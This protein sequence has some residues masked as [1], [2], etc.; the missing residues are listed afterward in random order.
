LIA[1]SCFSFNE[2]IVAFDSG[3]GAV[4][5]ARTYSSD[6]FFNYNKRIK[7]I[8]TS[9]GASP[10]TYVLSD[11]KA[12]FTSCTG[13]HF[14]KFDPKTVTAHPSSWTKKTTGSTNCGHLGLTFGRGESLLYAFSFFNSQSTFTLLDISGN[15]LW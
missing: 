3:S 1:H 4:L 14:F 11:Y 6:G 7:S 12:N 2:Y 10:M 13:Q 8:I 5:S 9:K 15:S